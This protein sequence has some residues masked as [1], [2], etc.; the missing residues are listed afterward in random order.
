M[1]H[2]G[3]W[4]WCMSGKPD[5]LPLYVFNSSVLQTPAGTHFKTAWKWHKKYKT[6]NGHKITMTNNDLIIRAWALS[7]TTQ[8]TVYTVQKNTM[9]IVLCKIGFMT[10][11]K[12]QENVN[13]VINHTVL[14]SA[15]G[16]FGNVNSFWSTYLCL[17]MQRNFL[18]KK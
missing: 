7:S 11:T 4:L 6:H 15:C 17:F 18:L 16:L 14:W 13:N 5:H 3:F 2:W 1:I 12:L 9:T 8:H 10:W